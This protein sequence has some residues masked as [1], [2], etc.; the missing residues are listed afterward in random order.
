MPPPRTLFRGKIES[1]RKYLPNSSF[2]FADAL[3]SSTFTTASLFGRATVLRKYLPPGV[4]KAR[5]ARSQ[6]NTIAERFAR[7]R[8]KSHRR[9]RRT[10]NFPFLSYFGGGVRVSWNPISR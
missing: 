4:F 8:L 6:A 3:L 9:S 2:V 7:R 1:E 10:S 5:E